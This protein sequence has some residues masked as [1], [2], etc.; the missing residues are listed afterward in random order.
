M[1]LLI[2]LRFR[3]A[4]VVVGFRLTSFVNHANSRT[5]WVTFIARFSHFAVRLRTKSFRIRFRFQGFIIIH[6]TL[7]FR[8]RTLRLFLIRLLIVL[9]LNTLR[10]RFRSEHTSVSQVPTSLVRLR[11]AEISQ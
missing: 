6:R 4:R 9:H 10:V 7:L 8:L 3:S 1:F 11:G 2:F 5:I